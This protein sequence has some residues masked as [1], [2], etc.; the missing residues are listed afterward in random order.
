MSSDTRP[1]AAAPS[2]STD[3]FIAKLRAVRES[4]PVEAREVRYRLEELEYRLVE[5]DRD[6]A[7]RS[8]G[9]RRP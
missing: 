3:P 4:L 6:D 8:A 7:P 5:V 2:P 9:P 1:K